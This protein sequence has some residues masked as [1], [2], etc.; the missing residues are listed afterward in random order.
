MSF[1]LRLLV[2]VILGLVELGQPHPILLNG[3]MVGYTMVVSM[4]RGNDVFIMV[5]WVTYSGSVP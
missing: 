5:S 3:Y 2:N 1:I 4:N